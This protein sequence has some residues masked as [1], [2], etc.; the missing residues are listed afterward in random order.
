MSGLS[1]AIH[2]MKKSK[3]THHRGLLRG[4]SDKQYTTLKTNNTGVISDN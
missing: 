1:G 3:L 2:D 4:K